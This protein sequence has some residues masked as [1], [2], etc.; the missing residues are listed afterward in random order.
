M[1]VRGSSSCRRS[2][3]LSSSQANAIT[4][5]FGQTTVEPNLS[6][7][8]VPSF[9]GLTPN[10]SPILREFNQTYYPT[11]GKMGFLSRQWM[12][13]GTSENTAAQ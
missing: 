1:K 3:A 7:L 12:T 9:G 6:Y 2:A 4:D 10:R 5:R 11:D 8:A 13:L